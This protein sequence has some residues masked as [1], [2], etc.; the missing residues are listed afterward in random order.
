MNIAVICFFILIGLVLVW[1]IVG[2]H[3]LIKPHKKKICI[4]DIPSIKS[5]DKFSKICWKYIDNNYALVKYDSE[6]WSICTKDFSN[7]WIKCNQLSIPNDYYVNPDKELGQKSLDDGIS[8]L[9]ILR[10]QIFNSFKKQWIKRHEV[11]VTKD[12]RFFHDKHSGQLIYNPK[13]KNKNK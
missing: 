7:K 2:W 5:Y 3:L 13:R 9:Y 1:W 12:K 10:V 6:H 4:S 11:D 8:D